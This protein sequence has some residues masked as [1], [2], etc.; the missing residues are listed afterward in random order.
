MVRYRIAQMAFTFLMLA[1]S[2]KYVLGQTGVTKQANIAGGW[3]IINHDNPEVGGSYLYGIYAGETHHLTKTIGFQYGLSYSWENNNHSVNQLTTRENKDF[4]YG[5]LRFHRIAA[6]LNACFYFNEKVWLHT[7]YN[8][9]YVFHDL[10]KVYH[11]NYK[12]TEVY[13]KSHRTFVSTTKGT[14]NDRLT[15]MLQVG[16]N[17]SAKLN[18]AHLM[19]GVEYGRYTKPFQFDYLGNNYRYHVSRVNF[20]SGYWW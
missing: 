8:I 10:T 7:G 5:K 3:T 18:K 15:N 6:P 4:A 1:T 20:I 9:G 13:N 14:Y 19:F 12:F 16:I 2:A 17:W 11:V